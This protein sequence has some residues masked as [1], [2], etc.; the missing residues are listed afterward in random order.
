MHHNDKGVYLNKSE[1]EFQ[2]VESRGHKILALSGD[3][4]W[5]TVT[6]FEQVV[7]NILDEGA[8]HLVIDMQN[9]RYVDNNSYSPLVSAVKRLSPNGGTVNLVGCS[10][11]IERKF[12]VTRLSTYIA[13]HPN[14]DD[15][16]RAI[17][18]PACVRKP[19]FNV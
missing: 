9:V 15:A 1:F 14:M 17:S 10:E 19:V 8:Q 4:D 3:L 13:L 2:V 7:V 11:R 16:I 18:D 6:Q 12:N 5:H